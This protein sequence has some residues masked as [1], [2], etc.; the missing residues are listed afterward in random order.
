MHSK[1]YADCVLSGTVAERDSIT[2]KILLYYHAGSKNH[3]C[4]AIVRTICALFSKDEITLYSFQPDTDYEFGLDQLASVKGCKERKEQYS[5]PERIQIRLHLLQEGAECYRE[6][7]K[8]NTDWAFSI[9][10]DNYCYLGQP[11]ELAYINREFYK[12]NIK[13][14]LIGCSINPEIMDR[15]A[16]QKDLS[17]YNL[18][19]AR[20][21]ITYEKMKSIG[22]ENCYLYPDPAFMLPIKEVSDCVPEG[23]YIGINISPLI[24]KSGS[25]KQTVYENYSKLMEYILNNTDSKIM[26]IPHVTVE[27]DNDLSALK[28]LYEKYQNTGRVL[29]VEEHD[30]TELKGYFAK[31]KIVVCARTHVSIAAYSL[32]IPTLVIGYSVKS[33]GIAT[34]LFGDDKHYV[35]PVDE[36][37]KE[38]DLVTAFRWIQDN[39]TR[40]RQQLLDKQQVIKG[41]LLELPELFAEK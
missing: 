19:I 25:D 1:H 38:D 27:W 13:T 15:A 33:K 23:D 5:I 21:T 29:K 37:K 28:D 4:E 22:L 8:E 35:V 39:A 34:D 14:A 7:L 41:Q 12:R 6:M 16:V 18:I 9:G 17:L 31:C 2:M 3:G 32:G 26:L 24:M 10:G 36:L 40:I 11:E 30:C 20:E